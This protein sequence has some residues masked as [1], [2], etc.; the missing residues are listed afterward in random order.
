MQL[1]YC[2]I[3]LKFKDELLGQVHHEDRLSAVPSEIKVPPH[4]DL[5]LSPVH[6]GPVHDDPRRR[7]LAIA[8]VAE[9]HRRVDAGRE[10]VGA[11]N[12]T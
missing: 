6:D 3:L 9:G 12:S 10:G 1:Q 5:S 2:E 4:L 8:H 7:G 11:G